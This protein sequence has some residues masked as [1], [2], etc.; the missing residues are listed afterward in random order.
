MGSDIHPPDVL[1]CHTVAG[2]AFTDPV[3]KP[4]S[5]MTLDAFLEPGSIEGQLRVNCVILDMVQSKSV[6]GRC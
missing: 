1:A 2:L 5:I 3:P 6:L 4:T